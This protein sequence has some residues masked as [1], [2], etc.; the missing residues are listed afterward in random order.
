MVEL[1]RAQLHA[2]GQLIKK[3]E[4]ESVIL[5]EVDGEKI[6]VVMKDSAGN[7]VTIQLNKYGQG[8]LLKDG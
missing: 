3:V 2:L 4:I 7:K 8:Q 6:N 1:N 5:A